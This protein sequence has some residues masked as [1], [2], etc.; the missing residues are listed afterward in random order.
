MG[1]KLKFIFRYL[2]FPI[3]LIKLTCIEHL[4]SVPGPM[5]KSKMDEIAVLPVSLSSLSIPS[6]FIQLCTPSELSHMTPDNHTWRL[7]P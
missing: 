6:L 1:Q 3:K 4:L 2:D 7:F 5:E